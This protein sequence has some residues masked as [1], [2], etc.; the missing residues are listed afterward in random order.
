MCTDSSINCLARALSA[1]SSS[2]DRDDLV[3]CIRLTWHVAAAVGLVVGVEQFVFLTLPTAP[4]QSN[5]HP[6]CRWQMVSNHDKCAMT[7]LEIPVPGTFLS[8]KIP[9]DRK[10]IILGPMARFERR[11]AGP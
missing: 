8:C 10:P 6:I 9:L 2:I 7:V 11:S 4:T 1:C 3:V 5:W